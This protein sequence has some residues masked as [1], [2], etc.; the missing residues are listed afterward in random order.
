MPSLISVLLFALTC[1]AGYAS[2][3]RRGP[4][5]E[6]KHENSSLCMCCNSVIAVEAPHA[7]GLLRPRR[8]A[9]PRGPTDAPREQ[10]SNKSATLQSNKRTPTR[11]A[12]R[13]TAKISFGGSGLKQMLRD[14]KQFLNW[15][16]DE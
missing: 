15:I 6:A 12:T 7:L 10:Q 16:L 11:Q 9:K 5:G 1:F 2:D 8:R 14:S 13:R 4:K 3:T